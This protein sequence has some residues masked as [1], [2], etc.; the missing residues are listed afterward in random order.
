M[1]LCLDRLQPYWDCGTRHITVR[2]AKS[3]NNNTVLRRSALSKVKAALTSRQVLARISKNKPV[4]LSLMVRR[5]AV[6]NWNMP[7]DVL[8]LPIFKY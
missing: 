3:G 1:S 5:T 6:N 8:P 4:G 7:I 2:P